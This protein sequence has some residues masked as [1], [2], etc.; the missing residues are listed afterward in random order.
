[1]PDGVLIGFLFSMF[2]WKFYAKILPI[3]YKNGV[4]CNIASLIEYILNAVIE[5]YI[6]I[7]ILIIHGRV[8]RVYNNT[9]YNLN[10]HSIQ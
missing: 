8:N 7:Y 5:R 2:N 1:M 4:N 6:L 9:A 10:E 3:Y